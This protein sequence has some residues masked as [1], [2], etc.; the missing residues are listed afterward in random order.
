[1]LRFAGR[2]FNAWHSALSILED[3]ITSLQYS[4]DGRRDDP[5]EV[6]DAL[7]DLYK[8]L[9]EQDV[10]YGLWCRQSVMPESK[11]AIS[12]LQFGCWQ[13]AQDSLFGA[14]IKSQQSGSLSSIP[15]AEKTIWEEQWVQCAK[16]L[17]QWDMLTSYAKEISQFD[18]QLECSWKTSDWAAMRE[19][20]QDP[21]PSDPG[22]TKIY[23]IYN[24]LQEWRLQD[25]EKHVQEA[26]Q[27]A[28]KNW[29]L[30]PEVTVQ[31]YVPLMQTFHQLVELNESAMLLDE[32]NKSMRHNSVPDL[33]NTITAWRE[34][35]PNKWD[36]VT[37]WYELLT[38]RNHVFKMLV[39]CNQNQ[40]DIKTALNA[41]GQHEETW[42]HI[43]FAE[44]ARKQGLPQVCINYLQKIMAGPGIEGQHT[45]SKIREEALSRLE[46]GSQ[47]DL[48]QG[49]NLINKANLDYLQN[50]RDR[51]EILRIKGE[52]LFRVP[53]Q[54]NPMQMRVSEANDVLSTAVIT[55]DTQ[56][57][58][59]V[60][61]GNVLHAMLQVTS[62]GCQNKCSY[63]LPG[64]DRQGRKHSSRRGPKKQAH[65]RC[66]ELLPSGSSLWLREGEDDARQGHLAPRHLR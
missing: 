44:S 13:K 1:M 41:L 30:L 40:Q 33:K 48:T 12:Y 31:A 28:L 36:E 54:R 64:E 20:V 23:D 10:M 47:H 24:A 3:Q 2:T 56:S 46:L 61:W 60:S 25:A 59:W 35:L 27:Y 29:C 65:S 18:L 39:E 14:M 21:M 62:Q 57:K 51:A 38:W 22:Q 45:Y 63:L 9:G 55:A 8:R 16:H 34:R 17:N 32:V 66:D 43:K 49:L 4:S 11:V 53:D 37:V 5:V 19:L 50:P 42:T 6:I 7:S 58:T 26:F 52:F 15:K